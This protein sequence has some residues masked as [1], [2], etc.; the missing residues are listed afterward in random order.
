MRFDIVLNN[1]AGL[2]WTTRKIKMTS[3]GKP[4]RPLVHVDDIC[5]A[6]R[7]A[8]EAPR[9]NIHNEILNVGD[10]AQN[11]RIAEI[12]GIIADVFDGCVV[13]YG[14]SGDSRSYRVSFDKIARHL[15]AFRCRWG[16]ERGA[17][18][19]HDIFRQ[20][21]LTDDLFSFRG[22][23]RLDQIRHL[24]ASGRIDADL[25]WQ[26]PARPVGVETVG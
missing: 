26:P 23:T 9:E 10:E 8:L 13:T 19:L 18:Q 4:W 7:L 12:A 6:I 16:A 2:A 3:D 1:L 11:Y 24:L 20:V 25:Y 17:R 14:Q 22:F 15:P 21:G 5:Q